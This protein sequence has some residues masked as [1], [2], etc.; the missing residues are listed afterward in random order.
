MRD[1]AK[2]LKLNQ[3]AARGIRH[4]FGAADDVHLREDGFHVRLHGAFTD[5]ESR[6]DLFVA[7]AASHQLEDFDL[8]RA[9][10]FAAD[11]LGE[12]GCEVHGHASFAGVH[13]TDAIHQC[14]ARCVLEKVAFRSG[15]NGT[16]DIFIAVECCQYDDARVLIAGADFFDCT[17]AIELRHSQIE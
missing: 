3:A 16:I 7:F 12:F 15:L 6:A 11:A 4:G 5:K 10:R 13:T 1:M 17:D 14:L 2:R 8:A 9:Q